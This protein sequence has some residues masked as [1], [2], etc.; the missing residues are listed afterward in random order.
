MTT[1]DTNYSG[2]NPLL[3]PALRM[4]R[5]MTP[6]EMDAIYYCLTPGQREQFYRRMRVQ[7]TRQ[8]LRRMRMR[9]VKRHTR[10]VLWA[11]IVLTATLA[12]YL[13]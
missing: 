7:R 11:C 1:Q 6:D 9:R 5:R 10:Y 12:L 3:T 4:G 2:P 13:I 8:T